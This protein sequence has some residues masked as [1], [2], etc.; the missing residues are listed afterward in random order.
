M[1]LKFFGLNEP[2]FALTPDPRYLYLSRRHQEGMAH[3]LYGI[4]R[5]GSGG[6]VQLTGEVGTGKTTLCRSLLEQTPE[7]TRLALILNPLLSPRELLAAI[8]DEL[9][10]AYPPGA[11]GKD[12]FDALTRFLLAA[13][14]AGEKVVVVIDEAQNLSRDA[15]EQVRLLTNLETTT[16]KLLQIVLLGQPEL[17][18]LLAKEDLRQLAQRIT[19]RYHLEP[20]ADDECRAYIRHRLAVAGAVRPPFTAAGIR[21]LC[22]VSRGVPRMINIIADRALMGAYATDRERV[23]A[24]L[25]RRSA[26]EIS[27]NAPAAKRLLRPAVIGFMVL[28]LAGAGFWYF[29]QDWPAAPAAVTTVADE[30]AQQL[31]GFTA[32]GD[33]AAAW[34]EYGA[35]WGITDAVSLTGVCT[36]NTGLA[37]YVCV[38]LEGTLAKVAHLGMPVMLVT[39]G[40]PPLLLRGLDAEHVLLHNGR[41]AQSFSR[42]ALERRW[43]GGFQVLAP[44]DGVVLGEGDQ[45]EAVHRIKA[46][47]ASLGAAAYTG[48]ADQRYDMKFAAWVREFQRLEGL[49]Q[50]GVVGAATRVYLAARAPDSPR[51]LEEW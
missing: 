30:E 7:R 9:A 8:C 26:R 47:A 41:S 29:R 22:R 24:R 5:G 20:L 23:G 3:L 46:L 6:F 4:N 14:G 37:G 15:L 28:L 43:R 48:P 13:H 12:L 40:A 2:P 16:D 19:A 33:P 31:D 51:L 42:A 25:V 10:V 45:R 17:R 11:G 32:A 27:G 39:P 35:L 34:A 38:T 49:H 50:D 21:A 36:S 1:Y 18:R 44:G